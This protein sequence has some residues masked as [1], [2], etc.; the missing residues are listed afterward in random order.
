MFLYNFNTICFKLQERELASTEEIRLLELA[1]EDLDLRETEE[2]LQEATRHWIA[3][4]IVSSRPLQLLSGSFG[5]VIGLLVFISL[6]M[7]K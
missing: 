6:F 1:H 7:D 3:Q 5:I 4:L 2:Q